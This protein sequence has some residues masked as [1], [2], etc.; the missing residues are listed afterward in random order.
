PEFSER[1]PE[2]SLLYRQIMRMNP[3]H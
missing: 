1:F 3:R 2:K